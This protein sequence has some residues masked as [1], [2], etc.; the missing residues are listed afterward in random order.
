MIVPERERLSEFVELGCRIFHEHR[1]PRA[2]L[3]FNLLGS[4]TEDLDRVVC[5]GG[6]ATAFSAEELGGTMP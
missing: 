5:V 1:I 3:R 2:K 4:L 6:K